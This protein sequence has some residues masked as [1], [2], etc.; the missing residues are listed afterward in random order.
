MSAAHWM[1]AKRAGLRWK[2]T[3]KEK[4]MELLDNIVGFPA[5]VL[6]G[7]AADYLIESGV[8]IPVLCGECKHWRQKTGQG[9]F[10]FK[11]PEGECRNDRY[12]TPWQDSRPITPEDH[13]CADGE[14]RADN[15]AV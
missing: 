7:E 10:S 9:I 2:M 14:R 11:L 12:L 13:Y 6:P 15:E 4:L 1:T 8:R 5:T 3:E